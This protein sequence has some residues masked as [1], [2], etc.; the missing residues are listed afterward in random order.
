MLTYT[1]HRKANPLMLDHMADGKGVV[2]I[3]DGF[4]WPG[5][6][7]P[8]FWMLWHRLWLPLTGYLSAVALVG[9]AGYLLSLPDGVTGSIGLLA[10]LFAGLEGNN[11]RRSAL[12]KRGYEEVA[13]IVA[14]SGEETSYRF[15]AAQVSNQN[16]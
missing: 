2:F 13:D 15:F 14:Q 16:G 6:V 5:L 10:N 11:F 12:V 3:K 1:V 4:S 8:F 7:I 9:V